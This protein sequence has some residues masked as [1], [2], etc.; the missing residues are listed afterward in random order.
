[1]AER[2]Y[3]LENRLLDFAATITRLTE[4]LPR[5]RSGNHVAIQLLRSGTSPLSN[6]GEAQSAESPSDFVHKLRICLKELRE[7]KRW[8]SLIRQ[9]PLI[10][11]PA[12]VD[13]A[14]NETE[15]LIRIFVA[16][17]RTAEKHRS[18]QS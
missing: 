11:P 14:L 18:A 9:V 13:P 8:L 15:E 1:M 3:D 4:K 6:H 10:R 7:T 17:I 16:S 2:K 5:T 12:Q